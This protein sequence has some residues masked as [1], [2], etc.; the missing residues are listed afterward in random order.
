MRRPEGLWVH[1]TEGLAERL[2]VH[3]GKR[4]RASLTGVLR[5]RL[6]EVLTGRPVKSMRLYLAEWLT[7][8]GRLAEWLTGALA[9]GLASAR[10]VGLASA[11]AQGLLDGLTDHLAE[12]LP[13]PRPEYFA[14]CRLHPGRGH[15]GYRH[16]NRPAVRPDRDRRGGA[17]D[18]RPGT[19]RRTRMEGVDLSW[20]LPGRA[21]SR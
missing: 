14:Q 2:R 11:L 19:R 12:N 15:R 8:W 9:V 4:L 16:I 17:D 1:L 18:A 13:A 5:G 3:L 7:G 21:N 10:A 6:T 20:V